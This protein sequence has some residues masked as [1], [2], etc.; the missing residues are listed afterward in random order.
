M[1]LVCK[2]CYIGDDTPAY[3][4]PPIGSTPAP[5]L[6]SVS[7]TTPVPVEVELGTPETEPPVET[8]EGDPETEGPVETEVGV[9]ET[10]PPVE[11]DAPAVPAPTPTPIA[12][13]PV[14]ALPAATPTPSASAYDCGPCEEAERILSAVDLDALEVDGRVLV[15]D[16]DCLT[17]SLDG[18]GAFG[19]GLV[20]RSVVAPTPAP[21]PA[22]DGDGE[23]PSPFEEG[24]GTPAPS[25]EPA[26]AATPA[27]VPAVVVTP[28]PVDVVA[29]TPAP[30]DVVAVTPA[31]VEVVVVTPAPVDPTPALVD[32]TPAPVEV[33]A[34]TPA[35]V[36]ATPSTPAPVSA[37]A[38][39]G[40]CT[41]EEEAACANLTPAQREALDMYDSGGKIIVCDPSCEDGVSDP[42]HCNCECSPRGA[43]FVSVARAVASPRLARHALPLQSRVERSGCLRAKQ[44]FWL[45]AAVPMFP[46]RS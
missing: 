42:I 11:T 13:T 16:P 12:T 38:S 3:D 29:V 18:C 9:P 15:C 35:P 14:P 39:S 6:A 45:G 8:E 20:C 25:S 31:P 17:E 28:A 36:A 43:V 22:A 30:V 4:D 21:V 33:V 24:S 26:V 5:T 7:G 34:A 27:P 23:T 1:P 37:D 19:L 41:P 32:P 40:L 10:E 44:R 46:P 2:A